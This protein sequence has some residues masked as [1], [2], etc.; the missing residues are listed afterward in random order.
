M[1]AESGAPAA[2]NAAT[3]RITP[4]EQKGASTP[5]VAAATTVTPTPPA[6]KTFAV[7]WSAALAR[8]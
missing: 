6:A 1:T 5:K 4:Q 2:S 8:A 3:T 7:S